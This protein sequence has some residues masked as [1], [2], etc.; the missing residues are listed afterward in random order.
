MK[1]FKIEIVKDLP[2]LYKTTKEKENQEVTT[3]TSS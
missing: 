3:M 1:Y 2:I